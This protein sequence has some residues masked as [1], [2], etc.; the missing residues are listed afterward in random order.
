MLAMDMHGEQAKWGTTEYLLANVIDLLNGANWQRSGSKGRAPSPFRR[1][2]SKSDP[3]RID[4]DVV[5]VLL[6]KLKAKGAARRE[7]FARLKR[8]KEVADG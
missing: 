1:P 5:P 7:R 4:P 6:K 2:T 8:L 3:S